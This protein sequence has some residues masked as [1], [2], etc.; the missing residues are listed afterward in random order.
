MFPPDCAP[1]RRNFLKTATAFAGVSGLM[2]LQEPAAYLQD[3]KK[4]PAS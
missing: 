3:A 4:M 2:L 1:S